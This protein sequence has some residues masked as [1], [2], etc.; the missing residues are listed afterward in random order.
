MKDAKV[1]RLLDAVW[2]RIDMAKS[3]SGPGKVDALLGEALDQ[4]DDALV[5]LQGSI[6]STTPSA[7]SARLSR[8]T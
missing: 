5:E 6:F 7:Y 3:L 4:L 2:N 8:R 1:V